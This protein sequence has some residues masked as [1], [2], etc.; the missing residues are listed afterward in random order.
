MI[1]MRYCWRKCKIPPWNQSLSYCSYP[2][3]IS[4]LLIT[5]KETNAFNSGSQLHNKR[6]KNCSAS[7]NDLDDDD[8]DNTNVY[9]DCDDPQT[10]VSFAKALSGLIFLPQSKRSICFRVLESDIIGCAVD[11]AGFTNTTATT[12]ISTNDNTPTSKSVIKSFAHFISAC[13]HRE[14]DPHCLLQMLQ[15][16]Q[17]ILTTLLSFFHTQP[18]TTN[19][20]SDTTTN[21]DTHIFPSSEIFDIV[22]PYYPV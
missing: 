10:G 6:C 5:I 11:I 14:T 4:I 15:L 19:P 17:S 13:L 1:K 12:N 2:V 3:R 8:H 16:L 9:G 22:P 7:L 18:H 21:F 20:T